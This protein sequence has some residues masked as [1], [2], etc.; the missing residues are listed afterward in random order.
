MSFAQVRNTVWKRAA[1]AFY[2]LGS[3]CRVLAMLV[4]V[5]M[6]ASTM[7]G[8]WSVFA[9]GVSRVGSIATLGRRVAPVNAACGAPIHLIVRVSIALAYLGWNCHLSQI[10]GVTLPILPYRNL[11]IALFVAQEVREAD[12]A[13]IAAM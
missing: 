5:Y 7:L 1:L 6:T 3:V 13:I 11:V 4:A 8:S 2:D 10:P 12:H 9:N